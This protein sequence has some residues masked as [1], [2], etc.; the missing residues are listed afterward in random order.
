MSLILS[1]TI[2]VYRLSTLFVKCMRIRDRFKLVKYYEKINRCKVIYLLDKQTRYRYLNMESMVI[3]GGVSFDIDDSEAMS[4]VFNNCNEER[5]D[6]IFVIDCGG[7]PVSHCDV[8][9]RHIETLQVRGLKVTAIIPMKA[10]S[11]ATAIALACNE[12]YMGDLACLS[13]TDPLTVDKNNERCSIGSLMRA[14]DNENVSPL[15]SHEMAIHLDDVKL[16]DENV[17][18]TKRYLK[19]HI[20]NRKD[21]SS[22]TGYTFN[23][24]SILN[25][26]VH[27]F[28][29]GDVSHHTPYGIPQLRDLKMS[30][31]RLDRTKHRD[32]IQFYKDIYTLMAMSF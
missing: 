20:M 2:G 11:A 29:S 30:V 23:K 14:V 6:I 17:K 9:N 13:P 3:G 4:D 8:I 7:G 26:A 19:R 21:K 27:A 15:S 25:K 22:T 1:I 31:R 24:E 16:Y 12:I 32:I 28:A 18:N 10:Y 5:R